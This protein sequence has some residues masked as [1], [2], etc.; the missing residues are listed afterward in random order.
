M[1]DSKGMRVCDMRIQPKTMKARLDLVAGLFKV[2]RWHV[3]LGARGTGRPER[4]ASACHFQCMFDL[5]PNIEHE[6]MVT[7]AAPA[8]SNPNHTKTNSGVVSELG[9][10]SHFSIDRAANF[11]VP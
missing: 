5:F 9:K 6:L 3:Q 1:P 10:H 8:R 4:I 2:P 11:A 7:W